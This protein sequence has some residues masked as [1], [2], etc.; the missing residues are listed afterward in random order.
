MRQWEQADGLWVSHE[1]QSL[2]ALNHLLDGQIELEAELAQDREDDDA[3][4]DGGD[5]VQNAVGGVEVDLAVV[6]L[7]HLSLNTE[8]FGYSDT[9]YSDRFFCPKKDLFILKIIG[10]REKTATVTLLPFPTSAVS[11]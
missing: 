3:R 8:N 4:N 5:E 7:V 10:Y 2:P 6:L 1:C 9:G 11:L